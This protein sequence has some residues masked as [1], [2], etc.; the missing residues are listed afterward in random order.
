MGWSPPYITGRNSDRMIDLCR[1]LLVLNKMG[2]EQG[3][4]RSTVSQYLTGVRHHY[5]V[6]LSSLDPQQQ[7]SHVWGT[8]GHRHPLVAMM[9][10]SIPEKH[11]PPKKVLSMEWIEDGFHNCWT[12]EEYVAITVL[13]G[14]VLRGGEGCDPNM[15]HTITW[16]MVQFSVMDADDSCRPL[17]MTDL[18]STPCDMVELLPTSRKYQDE[19]RP[20]PG[21]INMTHLKE[22]VTG[23]D[24]WC[25]LCM[26][27]I[28]QAWAIKNEVDRLT[29]T[30]RKSRPVFAPPGSTTPMSRTRLSNA[31][32]RNAQRRH[33]DVNTIMPHC[34]RKTG[35]TWLANSEVA[36]H[37]N[38][39]LRAIGH[40][41]LT[42]AEP[43]VTPDVHMARLTTEAMH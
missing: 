25:E 18:R 41:Q 35:I 22:P 8:P 28:L 30:E 17:Q 20:M 33:E 7:L 10:K 14:W 16:S 23:L 9:I 4:S 2:H 13:L 39:L 15:I 31:L 43:Y 26:P 42:S 24:Q 27:T 34:L 6:V 37:P 19:P 29:P 12:Q 11:R 21:R 32:R 1:I 38:I 5:A 3:L 36:N 40:K